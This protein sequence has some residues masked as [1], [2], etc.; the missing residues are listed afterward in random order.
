MLFFFT[1]LNKSGEIKKKRNV[2]IISETRKQSTGKRLSETFSRI[3]LASSRD[4]KHMKIYD[5]FLEPQFY[6]IACIYMA[7]RLFVNM[8]Q[9]YITFYV[10]YTVALPSEMIAI[11]PLVMFISGFLVS[12][13]LKF[14]TDRY[15]Y[16]IA[17]A[18]SYIVGIGISIISIRRNIR[19]F[20]R[21]TFKPVKICKI[22]IYN[23]LNV[24]S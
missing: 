18:L 3:S 20:R 6:V 14:I 16:K 22:V 24:S 11:I 19:I 21:I 13:L 7:C 5:W 2:S 17:F 15:G 8:S 4:V 10:Q 1:T 23:L 9:S 12:L